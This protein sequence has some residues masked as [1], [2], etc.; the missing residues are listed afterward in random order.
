MDT[1]PPDAALNDRGRNTTLPE[2]KDMW[3]HINRVTR[4]REASSLKEMYKYA[5]VE[6]M[7]SMAG[8][9]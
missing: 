6:G 4:N 7:I 3:H 9:G 8:G 5:R 1:C 2:A